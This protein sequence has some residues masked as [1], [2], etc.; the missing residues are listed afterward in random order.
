MGISRILPVTLWETNLLTIHLILKS[1]EGLTLSFSSFPEL[2]ANNADLSHTHTHTHTS[3]KVSISLNYY[4]NSCF[5]QFWTVVRNMISAVPEDIWLISDTSPCSE[6]VRSHCILHMRQPS[7]SPHCDRDVWVHGPPSLTPPLR[8]LID[9]S[10]AKLR[11]PCSQSS[12]L[13]PLP[14]FKFSMSE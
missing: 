1:H 9:Y 12:F 10:Q 7:F 6:P 5:E 13:F 2:L 11:G 14:H 8:A 3:T 4:L